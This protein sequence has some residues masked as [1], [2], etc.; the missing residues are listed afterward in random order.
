MQMQGQGAHGVHADHYSTRRCNACKS[1]EKHGHGAGQLSCSAPAKEG[2]KAH[3][4]SIMPALW[5]SNHF[6]PTL[7]YA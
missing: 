7:C 5:R 6:E 1:K 4:R 2:K 3:G